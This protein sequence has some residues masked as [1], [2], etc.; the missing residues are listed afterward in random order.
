MCGL[1]TYSL[2]V[3]AVG[4]VVQSGRRCVFVLGVDRFVLR[5]LWFWRRL[6]PAEALKWI[7]KAWG[8]CQTALPGRIS[9]RDECLSTSRA[10]THIQS[11]VHPHINTKFAT[12]YHRTKVPT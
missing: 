3:N 7:E 5:H 9:W 2:L 1:R 6:L 8:R 12:G 10:K 4:S 11:T